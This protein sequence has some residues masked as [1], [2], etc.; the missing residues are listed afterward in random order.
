MDGVI[1]NRLLESA[2]VKEEIA[3]SH[4]VKDIVEIV[5]LIVN[6][7]RR[8]G[9]V[10]LFGNGGSAADAQHLAAEFVG[11]FK[12]ERTPLPAIS[13]TTNTS[14]I[15]AIGND[16]GFDGIFEREVSCMAC[17]GDVVIGISTSGNSSN[18]LKALE[19]AESIGAVTVALTGAGGGRIGEVVDCLVAVPSNDTPRIQEAHIAI[20]HIICELVEG[21]LFGK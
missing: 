10:I 14:T 2:R 7:F 1:K 3:G 16:Y 11:R 4:A 6:C 13:L 18:V 12:L 8:G 20:G 19:K 15:T 17:K 5:E 21:E 9:K